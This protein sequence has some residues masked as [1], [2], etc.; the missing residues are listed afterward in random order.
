MTPAEQKAL[1]A[2]LDDFRRRLD[3][4]DDRFKKLEKSIEENTT[5][6]KKIDK[7]TEEI[8]DALVAAKV[9]TKLI[10][11]IGALAIALAAVYSLYYQVTHDGRL[12]H[13]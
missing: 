9:G 1:E 2:D 5:L 13:Q 3:E 7:S 12:P 6:T 11:W 10:K 8:R 4:G